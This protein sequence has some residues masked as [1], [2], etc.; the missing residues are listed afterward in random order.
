MITNTNDSFWVGLKALTGDKYKTNYLPGRL[1]F[2]NIK[3]KRLPLVL[4]CG[5]VVILLKCLIAIFDILLLQ[6]NKWLLPVC[7]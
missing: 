7:F 3:M 4:G 5:V 2:L 6:Y 1:K